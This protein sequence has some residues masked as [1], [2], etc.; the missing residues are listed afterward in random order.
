M[1]MRIFF[2]EG[3]LVVIWILGLLGVFPSP[4]LFISM[5]FFAG[6]LGKASRSL[7]RF[8][9]FTPTACAKDLLVGLALPMDLSFFLSSCAFLRALGERRGRIVG[10]TFE[11]LA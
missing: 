1:G 7:R 5:V 10:G 4:T 6:N 3:P 8:L 9:G 2:L 11:T